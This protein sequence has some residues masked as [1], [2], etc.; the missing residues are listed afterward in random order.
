MSAS[1]WADADQRPTHRVMVLPCGAHCWATDF[2]WPTKLG[3][4]GPALTA[5]ATGLGCGQEVPAAGFV[6]ITTPA[7][8][9]A[10]V[11]LL[12]VP[13]TSPACLSAVCAA[14]SVPPVTC[15][16]E[17]MCGPLDTM[18][19]TVAP[20]VTRDPIAGTVPTTSPLGTP[21]SRTAV[22]ALTWKPSLRNSVLAVAAT[23]PPS[24]GALV[25]LPTACHHT[26]VPRRTMASTP[27]A[28]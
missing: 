13:G 2:C 19:A 24:S 9:V 16:T 12:T 7:G 25:Y 18:S 8:I 10:E 1:E 3:T 4:G 20:V 6:L 17:I 28:R 21:L 15:G 5:I 26:T 11:S 23:S 22:P 27:A 14:A